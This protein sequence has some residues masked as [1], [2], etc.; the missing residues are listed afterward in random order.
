M[1]LKARAKFERVI[2]TRVGRVRRN[3]E[4]FEA[5]EE[6]ANVLLKAGLV[7]VIEE[8]P[9]KTEEPMADEK[10]VRQS[11]KASKKK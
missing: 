7:D 3:G 2:D 10:P 1:K 8:K 11:K 9:I 4:V 6:R 5:D